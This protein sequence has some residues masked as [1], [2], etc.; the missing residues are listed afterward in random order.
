[1]LFPA[2]RTSAEPLVFGAVLIET[3]AS[4]VREED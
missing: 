3:L 2:S 4:D 1:M